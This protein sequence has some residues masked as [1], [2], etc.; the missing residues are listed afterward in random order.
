MILRFV[1]ILNSF[2]SGAW[3][4][5][6]DTCTCTTSID[7]ESSSLCVVKNGQ[8]KEMKTVNSL[9]LEGLHRM[10]SNKYIDKLVQRSN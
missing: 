10:V 7:L 6:G 1:L 2:L 8:N 5:S 3:V 9:I 4:I